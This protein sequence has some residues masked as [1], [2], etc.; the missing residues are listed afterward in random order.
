MNNVYVRIFKTSS[1]RFMI[2]ALA[3]LDFIARIIGTI[4]F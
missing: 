1:K 4:I 3:L 2:N